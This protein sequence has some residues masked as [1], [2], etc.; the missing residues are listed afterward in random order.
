MIDHR[1]TRRTAPARGPLLQRR[2][3]LLAIPAMSALLHCSGHGENAPSQ[4]QAISSF[5]AGVYT[6]SDPQSF[7]I[8]GGYYHWSGLATE[9]LYA[10]TPSNTYQQ[11][12]FVASGSGFTICNV[13]DG[14]S[15]CLSDGGNGALTVGATAGVWSITSSGSGYTI[16]DQASGGYV[17]D[18]SSPANGAAVPVS[19]TGAVWTL[20]S[21]IPSFQAGTY[22]VS[23]ATSFAIDG[24]YYHWSGTTTEELY[25]LTPSNS[26]QQWQFTVS[27]SGFTICNIGDGTGVCLSDG[28]LALAV[29]KAKDVWTVAPSGSGYTIQNQSTQRYVTDA[30][31]P[32]DGAAVGVSSTATVWTLG[33][34]SVTP[35]PPPPPPPP[36]Q[37]GYYI[38]TNGDDSNPGTL[39]APFASFTKAQNAMRNSSIKTT[40]IRAGNYSP[41]DS[42]QCPAGGAD[43]A[44]CVLQLTSADNGETW[45]YYPPD[46]YDTASISGGTT[47]GGYNANEGLWS[48]FEIS[49]VSNLT[50]D[51]LTLH[52]F[53]S[54]AMEASW[55]SNL[56]ITNNV[57][58]NE[59]YNAGYSSDAAGIEGDDCNDCVIS[60]NVVHDA[61]TMGIRW[62]TSTNLQ[63]DSNVVYNTCTGVGDCGAIYYQDVPMTSTG[64]RITN[65]YVHDGNLAGAG[66]GNGDVGSGIYLDDCTSNVTVS[67]NVMTGRNGNNTTMIHGG[68]NNVFSGNLTDLSNYDHLYMAIQT[69]GACTVGSVMSGNQ[70]VHNIV[71]GDTQ[72][73][74]GNWAI[75]PGQNPLLVN[76]NDFYGYDGTT[77]AGGGSYPDTNSANQDPQLSCWSYNIASGSPIDGAPTSFPALKRGWGPPG[78]SIPQTG[79][80]PSS[81]GGC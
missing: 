23:D 35:P 12:Q 76:D 36:Q 63:I 61:Y 29:G 33:S 15:V 6:I 67:G 22:T 2:L 42:G 73:G 24:G 48:L 27:G 79:T 4:A 52:D 75:D 64:V 31:T 30:Q 45:Q 10:L 44:G 59:Y 65:N 51:G 77:V 78:Y 54:N 39:D 69:S 7:A 16:Q 58:Y 34:S 14:T 9:E 37:P 26:Y 49:G 74:V 55:C 18:A 72:M 8:D 38:A 46:G 41:G 1:W 71:V 60:H 80:P 32:G 66:P 13:G 28:G 50:I 11:W 3:S 57:V 53:N 19:S 21:L 40:Y 81:P 47:V 56:T 5:Q 20:T 70:Y 25:T 17:A 62:Y 68:S 43:T